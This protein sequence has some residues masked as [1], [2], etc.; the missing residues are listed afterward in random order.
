MLLLVDIMSWR[1]VKKR[2]KREP[3]KMRKGLRINLQI[4]EDRKRMGRSAEL[5]KHAAHLLSC[6][7]KIKRG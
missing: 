5:L 7:R 4:N 2:L 6:G 1:N 3:A